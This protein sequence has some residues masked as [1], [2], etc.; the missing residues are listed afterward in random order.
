MSRAKQAVFILN[1][2]FDI[3]NKL[4]DKNM[5]KI[6]SG[7]LIFLALVAVIAGGGIFAYYN[8]LKVEKYIIQED[9]KGSKFI[10]SQMDIE[11]GCRMEG[12]FCFAYFGHY[13]FKNGKNDIPIDVTVE[14]HFNKVTEENV[15]YTLRDKFLVDQ[16][17][18]G[19]WI[20]SYFLGG[21]D[22]YGRTV[23]GWSSGTMLITI[24]AEKG[25]GEADYIEDFLAEYLKKYP[26]NIK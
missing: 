1:I 3:I 9:I 17:A 24:T 8:L 23:I 14:Q 20:R 21:T 19:N 15:F 10:V 22:N 7:I 5:N 11:G 25:S 13:K 6:I 2:F 4:S 16:L 26:S 12:K 18:K